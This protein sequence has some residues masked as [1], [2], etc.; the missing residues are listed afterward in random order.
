MQPVGLVDG[1]D[2]VLCYY[3]AKLVGGFIDVRGGMKRPRTVSTSDVL[4]DEQREIAHT[5]KILG[6]PD[7]VVTRAM[8]RGL[9]FRREERARLSA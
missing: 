6:A 7:W 5:L 8:T 4:T 3:H 2:D 1:R 9:F